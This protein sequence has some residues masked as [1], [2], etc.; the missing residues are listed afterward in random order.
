MNKQYRSMPVKR[1]YIPKLNGKKR[2]LGLLTV[3][4]QVIQQAVLQTL[5]T[6]YE[7]IFSDRSYGFRPKIA[8]NVVNFTISPKV[9]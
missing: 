8:M 9:L 6:V 3:V 1:V 2:P 7:P 4:D 5:T